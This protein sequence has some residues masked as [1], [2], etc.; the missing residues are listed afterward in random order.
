MA[1]AGFLA[2]LN[3]GTLVI[4]LLIAAVLFALFMRKRSNRH[5]MEG[6]KERNVGADIDAGVKAPDHSER[7]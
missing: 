3:L 7:Q 1:E 2:S 4:V 5:P 6:R